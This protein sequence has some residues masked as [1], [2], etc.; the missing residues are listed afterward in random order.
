MK[1]SIG[2]E[3][4]DGLEDFASDLE[5]NIDFPAKF[6]SRKIAI[7]VQPQF[8]DP[9]L[10]KTTRKLL[11]ASQAVFAQFLGVAVKTV[12]AWEQGKNIPQDVACRLM[13]EIRHNPPYWQKRLR[14]LA[15]SKG[16]VRKATARA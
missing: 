3:I 14:E 13:D 4:I 8:Y 2:K 10:V 11:G 6:T 7:D 12:S 1:R 5:A 9:T 15:V 16:A